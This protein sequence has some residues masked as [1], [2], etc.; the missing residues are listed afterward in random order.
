MKTKDL[1]KFSFILMNPPY[2][3][4]LHLKIIDATVGNAMKSTGKLVVIH[5]ARWA[6]DLVSDLKKTSSIKRFKSAS[7]VA[8]MKL[9]SIHDSDEIF[10]NN[11]AF[12]DNLSVTTIK[13]EEQSFDFLSLYDKDFVKDIIDKCI[14]QH[15]VPYLT[16]AASD[17]KHYKIVIPYIHGHVEQDDFGELMSKVYEKAL[18]ST[19]SV[20]SVWM[21]FDTESERKN[22]F[23]STHT[24]F[25][26]KLQSL[27]K[28]GIHTMPMY[29][30]YMQD[31]TH[32][33]KDEDFCK[34]FELTDEEAEW[35]CD[36]NYKNIYK[37]TKVS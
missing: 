23:L 36:G 17:D 24:N 15:K 19:P 4:N 12:H 2:C 11:V 1:D 25:H 27:V 34:F 33:Y 32:Q 22:F 7:K 13:N 35:M 16:E 37:Y 31:Y 21:S 10:A 29:M 14:R 9:L 3:K 20:N 30:P 6:T 28:V 26:K 8:D 18:S 5:P